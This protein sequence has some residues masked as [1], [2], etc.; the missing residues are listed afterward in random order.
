M[1]GTEHR[2]KLLSRRSAVATIGVA[3]GGGIV[4]VGTVLSPSGPSY[5]FEPGSV[6]VVNYHTTGHTV[7]VT[8]TE[9]PVTPSETVTIEPGAPP[10]ED[11]Q[12]RLRI[13]DLLSEP[14]SYDLKAVLEDGSSTEWPGVRIWTEPNG[15]LGG[16]LPQVLIEPDGTIDIT[17]FI[18]HRPPDERS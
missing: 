16:E 11:N 17:L 7:T 12:A 15:A 3:I 9:G 5:S 1:K 6:A 8:V 10:G 18:Q 2:S 4:G 14:G 13:A